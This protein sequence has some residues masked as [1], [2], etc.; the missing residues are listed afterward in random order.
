[1]VGLVHREAAL[2][3]VPM[4]SRKPLP[5]DVERAQVWRAPDGQHYRVAL[6]TNG[7][8]T[9]QRCTPAGHVLNTRYNRASVEVARMQAGWELVTGR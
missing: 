5:D 6:V 4:L 7:I 1:M 3:S 8:A 9:L 2:V